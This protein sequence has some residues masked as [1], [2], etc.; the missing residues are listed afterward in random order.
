MDRNRRGKEKITKW[1]RMV[2]N[3]KNQFIPTDYELELLKR[4]QNLRQK[5]RSMKEY[6]EEFYKMIIRAG[7]SEESKEK[8]V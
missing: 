2:T 4:L 8:V 5:E 1:D 7:H 6:I 3:M